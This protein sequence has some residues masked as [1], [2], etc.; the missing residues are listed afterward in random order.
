MIIKNLV[1]KKKILF[2]PL[3]KFNNN[4]VNNLD[5]LY[6]THSLGTQ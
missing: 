6:R 3:Y 5:F 1:L 4:I 2:N